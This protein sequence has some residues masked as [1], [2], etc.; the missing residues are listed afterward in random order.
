M[1]FVEFIIRIAGVTL[2]LTMA[3]AILRDA[4]DVRQARFG[5]FL[6]ITLSG[7]LAGSESAGSI[8]PPDWARILFVPLGSSSAI[9]IWWYSLSL[10]D[11]DF[12]LG[13]LEW[14][15]AGVWTA[16]GLL[17]L[18]SFIQQAPAEFGW[19]SS[20]RY[21]IAF[22]L[23]A[24]IAYVAISGRKIDLVEGRR[25][26]RTIY[27]SMISALFLIDLVSERAYGAYFTPLIINVVQLSAFLAVILW[28]FYWLFRMEKSVFAFEKS[29]PVA[30][31]APALSHKDAALKEKLTAIM[32][33]ER[34]FLET[35]LSIGALAQRLGAPEHHLRAFIN[36]TMGHRN[37]R[38]YL[39]GYRLEAAK[40]ALADPEKAAL[41][42]LTI[43][44]DSGFA[45]LASFNRAFK[46]TV[47]KTPSAYRNRENPAL[48]NHQN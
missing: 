9:F 16:L 11:D 44:M 36:K 4:W 2:L 7:V 18:S 19:A 8:S 31:A 28:S 39:N 1:Q 25:R 46:E 40:A 35:D 29:A 21:A 41:P 38:S 5:F 22:G 42:I 32:E 13:R 47:G 14:T 20:A 34:A 27:A 45:S 15:V 33:G 23:V 24:H 17:N 26:A 10:F 6:A 12:R 3:G 37:F 30:P 43:A 48:C